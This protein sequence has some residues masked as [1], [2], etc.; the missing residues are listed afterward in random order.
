ME[1]GNVILLSC[2]MQS[3]TF[4]WRNMNTINITPYPILSYLIPYYPMKWNTGRKNI[5]C[6]DRG[7]R[8]KAEGKR[9]KIRLY[10]L[11]LFSRSWLY[12]QFDLFLC[13]AL[14]LSNFS[15]LLNRQTD[16]LTTLFWRP[17]PA[18]FEF[19]ILRKE[20]NI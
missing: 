18:H 14:Y 19:W 12:C 8:R 6:T 20:N 10:L 7:K 5:R 3:V 1:V 9:T 17:L 15:N 4:S 11:S 2:H 13:P 16:I